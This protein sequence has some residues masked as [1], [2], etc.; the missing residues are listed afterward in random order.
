[1]NRKPYYHKPTTNSVDA[2]RIMRFCVRDYAERIARYDHSLDRVLSREQWISIQSR[3]AQ[4]AEILSIPCYIL[5][6]MI[7]GAYYVHKP[8]IYQYVSKGQH[9]YFRPFLSPVV[10]KRLMSL[11][12]RDFMNTKGAK[13]LMLATPIEHVAMYQMHRRLDHNAGILNINPYMFRDLVKGACATLKP[14]TTP[15]HE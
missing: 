13:L 8:V 12:M 9:K 6:E 3:Q 15:K 2:E 4:L 11:S 7:R 14:L 5:Q 10:A 1:M